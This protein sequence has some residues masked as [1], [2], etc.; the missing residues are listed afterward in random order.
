MRN[1]LG[2]EWNSLIII[3]C[4]AV[5]SSCL[6][7]SPDPKNFLELRMFA[8]NEVWAL[9]VGKRNFSQVALLG[10]VEI[11]R[12][13]SIPH[14]CLH[15]KGKQP[16]FHSLNTFIECHEVISAVLIQDALFVQLSFDGIGQ[17]LKQDIEY[18]CQKWAE[19]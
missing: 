19:K 7:D 10:L 8:R 12:D 4:T 6:T 2:V 5:S 16:P 18:W 9:D 3:K 17:S 15:V 11:I 13:Q 1:V 14:W